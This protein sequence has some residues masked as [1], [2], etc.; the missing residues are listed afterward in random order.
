M[1]CSLA[2]GS[3]RMTQAVAGVGG[4][5]WGFSWMLLDVEWAEVKRQWSFAITS[6]RPGCR[7]GGVLHVAPSK[8][9]R[10][11]AGLLPSATML[12]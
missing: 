8:I 12:L 10:L 11:T 4:A 6:T 7:R 1:P 3:T 5:A 9:W 2:S